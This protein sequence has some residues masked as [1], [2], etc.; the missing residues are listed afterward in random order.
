MCLYMCVLLFTCFYSTT[1]YAHV[2]E[3]KDESG[4]IFTNIF[5]VSTIESFKNLEYTVNLTDYQNK[6]DIFEENINRIYYFCKKHEQNNNCQYYNIFVTSNLQNFIESRKELLSNRKPRSLVSDW[7]VTSVRD[8]T[9]DMAKHIYFFLFNRAS[10]QNSQ[11]AINSLQ[12]TDNLLK[13]Y[14]T[15]QVELFNSSI[16][17]HKNSFDKTLNHLQLFNQRLNE[18]ELENFDEKKNRQL[19]TIISSATVTLTNHIILTNDILDIIDNK[20]ISKIKNL[21]TLNELSTDISKIKN[22]LKEHEV[23]PAQSTQEILKI[24]NIYTK[25]LKNQLKITIKIPITRHKTHKLFSVIEIP[26]KKREEMIEIITSSPYLL[27]RNQNEL[28][29]FREKDLSN[30]KTNNKGIKICLFYQESEEHNC[31]IDLFLKN[32]DSKCKYI[33]MIPQS[34]LIKITE[35]IFHFSIYGKSTFIINCKNDSQIFTP[36]NNM[37]IY[38]DPGCLIK[39]KNIEYFVPN[40]EYSVKT[41]IYLPN[42]TKE[43]LKIEEA[44]FDIPFKPNNLTFNHT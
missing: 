41:E 3:N 16:H 13:N 21:I 31:E 26:I 34:Y 19:S 33:K 37:I 17:L 14:T 29:S 30:C 10:H 25:F 2:A 9:F 11:E 35:N 28:V 4:V 7:I 40:E 24:S 32:K 5:N 43:N 23:I 27:Q 44:L 15:I 1:C 22:S 42:I 39:Y 38:L 20:D 6:T 18:L 36:K 8:F 12:R